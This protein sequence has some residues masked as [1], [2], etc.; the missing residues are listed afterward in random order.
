MRVNI[1]CKRNWG[2]TRGDC[3]PLVVLKNKFIKKEG[4]KMAYYEHLPIYKKAME[5]AVYF[6]KI[7]PEYCTIYLLRLEAPRV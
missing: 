1:L 3:I 2:D 4:T 5:T 7:V 6:E